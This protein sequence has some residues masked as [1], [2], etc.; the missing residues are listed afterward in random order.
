MRVD[1]PRV[2]AN[3]IGGIGACGQALLLLHELA[4]CYPYKMMSNP[5]DSFYAGIAYVGALVAP[6]LAIAGSWKLSGRNTS[7]TPAITCL[8]CPLVFLTVFV[9]AH[10]LAGVDLGNTQN[11]EQTS[12]ATVFFEFA[13]KALNLL[14]EGVVI[15]TFTGIGIWIGSERHEF[16]TRDLNS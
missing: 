14:L 7:Y 13:N 15:G 5:S 4:D 10:G 16:A 2:V 6:L 9:V 8:L 12:P 1:T 3:V 11:F